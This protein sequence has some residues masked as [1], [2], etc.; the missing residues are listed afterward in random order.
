MK[1]TVY[2]KTG[3]DLNVPMPLSAM[4]TKSF[5]KLLN[6]EENI[7]DASH[8]KAIK[9]MVGVLDRYK[10]EYGSFTLVDAKDEEGAGIR[11][12]I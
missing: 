9:E 12:V 3:K 6:L 5:W 11:I 1:I 4:T 10:K 8:Q 7:N 2:R